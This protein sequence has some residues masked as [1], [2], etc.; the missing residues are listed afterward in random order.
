MTKTKY[1]AGVLAL[2]FATLPLAPTGAAPRCYPTSRFV[3]LDGG[4]VQD[5]LTNLVWQQQ[6]G[7][8][9]NCGGSFPFRL[10]TVKE[11]LS[12]VDLTVSSGP[13]IDQTAFPN[14]P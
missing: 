9:R 4:L 6:V 10:P 3:V 14:T 1:W 12:L 11:L 13:T 7:F 8:D 2:A 5:P